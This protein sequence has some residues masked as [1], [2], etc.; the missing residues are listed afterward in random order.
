M[1]YAPA[2]SSATRSP[3]ST[4]FI[5]RSRAKKSPVS[6]TGPNNI[7]RPRAPCP[8][9]HWHNLVICLIKRWPNQIVH[10]RIGNY[11]RLLP[12]PLD[13]QHACHQ[14]AG[15]RNDE[16]SWL[17]QQFAFEI[18]QC[19]LNRGC[20][21]MHFHRWRTSRSIHATMVIN[22]KTAAGIHHFQHN[23]FALQLERKFASRAPSPR[24]TALPS[25]SAIQYAR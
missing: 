12:V 7:Y 1:P 23:A 22:P 8:W 17:N 13:V 9:P 4:G 15:L 3:A 2:S 20:I 25:E 24:Q 16:A 19:L 11:E 14:R 5:I 6:Q 18:R 10:R 21:L